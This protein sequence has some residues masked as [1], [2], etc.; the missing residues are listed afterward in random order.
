[1][2][3]LSDLLS[4]HGTLLDTEQ[5]DAVSGHV[6]RHDA[7]RRFAQ[8]EGMT[9][10]EAQSG[11]LLVE[12]EFAEAPVHLF[13]QDV[14]S[15]AH[16][17]VRVLRARTG[18]DGILAP[19]EEIFSARISEK[20]LTEAM[21]LSN[22]GEGAPMTVTRLGSFDLPARG[23]T[24]LTTEKAAQAHRDEQDSAIALGL[25]EL[26]NL[27]DENL[28]RSSAALRDAVK[29]LAYRARDLLSIDFTIRRHLEQMAKIRSQVL[30][31]AAH[32]ALHADKV[33]A[34]LGATTPR[35]PS[36]VPQ[37]WEKTTSDHP[38]VN[39]A[40]DPMPQAL[41]DAIRKMIVAEI[42]RL[43]RD[44]PKLQGW[45]KADDEGWAVQ[46]PDARER[47]IAIGWSEEAKATLRDIEALSVIW[48]WA[49]NSY[50]AEARALYRADQATLSVSQRTGWLG[51]I[52]SSLPPTE[53]HYFNLAI[54]PAW[55]SDEM[56]LVKVRSRSMPMLEIEI[57][58]EDL[59]TALRG[60]PEGHPVPCS[61]RSLC[62]IWRK[63]VERPVHALSTD[64]GEIEAAL[65]QT[66]EALELRDALLH[67]AEVA[68]AKR[69][70]KAWRED[71]SE[72]AD[73]VEA[74]F[75]KARPRTEEMLKI[76]RDRVDA[77]VVQSAEAMLASIAK[78]LPRDTLRL[79]RITRDA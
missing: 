28:V 40:L 3:T 20:S 51:N 44:Y 6:R 1:M 17:R 74:A 41:R 56:A 8:P 60:H 9:D 32:A 64:I 76:G 23:Q 53:G 73:A 48:N 62:G 65:Q 68:A 5:H 59:M 38:M 35:L 16:T 42:Q 54:C 71:L 29:G 18:V 10:L 30:T 11:F 14:L 50:I 27:I 77:H 79:L 58:A 2:T 69:T 72:A 19:A 55:E 34:T 46:F 47:S 12:R 4:R 49:F 25:A 24:Q 39:F 36:P 66:P 61:L 78:S 21:L 26:R 7:T 52:H 57:V 75:A 67:L 45:I 43:A 31:E 63:Q 70:G 15:I 33:A 22:R 13:G 37:D